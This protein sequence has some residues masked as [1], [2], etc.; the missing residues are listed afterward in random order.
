MF[1]LCFRDAATGGHDWWRRPGGLW[2][3]APS[4]GHPGLRRGQLPHGTLPTGHDGSYGATRGK[5]ATASLFDYLFV[6]SFIDLF[7]RFFIH[8]LF[9]PFFRLFIYS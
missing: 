1:A 6:R 5:N 8:L 3:G 4:G 2:G 9:R 7:I